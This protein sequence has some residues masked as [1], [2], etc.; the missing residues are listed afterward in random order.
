MPQPVI[1]RNL[2]VER[3]KDIA[4]A[5]KEVLFSKYQNIVLYTGKHTGLSPNDKFIV[6]TKRLF[7]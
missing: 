4:L 5:K 2:S 7:P 3:L 6:Q 1:Y